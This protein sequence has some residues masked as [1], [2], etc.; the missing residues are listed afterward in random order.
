MSAESRSPR[1]RSPSIAAFLSFL[2]PGLGQWY[3]RRPRTALLYAVPVLAVFAVLVL[4][5]AGGLEGLVADVIDPAVAQTILLL[6]IALGFWRI[7]SMVDASVAFGWAALRGRAGVV[8][9]GLSA[10]VL[11]THLVAGYYAWAVYDASSRIFVG[12]GDP[13]PTGPADGS[14]TPTDPNAP[15]PSDDYAATP[16]RTP[17]TA[18]SRVTIL[19]TGIDS[20]PTRR[21]SLTDTLLV[22]SVDPV[23]KQVAMVSFPRDLSRLPLYDGG[24]YEG[25]INSFMTYAKDHPERFPDGPLPSLVKELSFLLGVPIHY[26]AAVDMD[27]FRRMVKEVGGVTVTVD[28]AINDPAYD[29]LDGG[30]N[31]FFLPAG[32]QTLDPRN[33]LAYVRTRQ[34]AGD[35]D[36]NRA[37]RQQ[38]VLLALRS[39][40]VDPAMLPRIPALLDVAGDTIRTNFPTER[41]GAM[42]ELAQ[43]VPDDAIQRFVLGPRTYAEQ[44]PTSETG[45]IYQLRLKMDVLADLSVRL[46]G[47]DSAYATAAGPTPSP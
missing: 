6:I 5:A 1:R 17:E 44:I 12:Q 45:G 33:A 19:L 25:K 46:F 43:E 37:R 8:L 41:V 31:G 26:Y 24:T 30:P 4:R 20:A 42:L 40:L 9:V 35:N 36:F 23:S 34:G 27:G 29:W 47:R 15:A 14:P 16:F 39:K 10:L 32:T 28:R 22:V 3:L 18:S 7:L 13:G 38:Q 11:A 21:A 2:W